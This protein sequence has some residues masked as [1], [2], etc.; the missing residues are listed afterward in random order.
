MVNIESAEWYETGNQYFPG[1]CFEFPI[2][3]NSNTH[4]IQHKKQENCTMDRS[5]ECTERR[6]L[7]KVFHWYSDEK[8]YQQGNS[9]QVSK[10]S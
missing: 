8:Q 5:Q 7:K 10:K 4:R 6:V 3:L 9:L 1:S 2:L